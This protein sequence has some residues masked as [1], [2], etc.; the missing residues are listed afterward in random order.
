[1]KC[2]GLI[3]FI[4]GALAGATAAILLAP[5]SGENTRR[6]LREKAQQEYEH[7]KDKVAQAKCDCTDPNCGCE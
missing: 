1:M 7:L 6:K 3:A 4:G 5:D 2:K